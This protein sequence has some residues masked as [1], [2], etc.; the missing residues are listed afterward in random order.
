M[1]TTPADT[2]VN[3]PVAVPMVAMDVTPHIHVPPDVASLRVIVAPTHTD[4]GPDIAAGE[5][6]TVT[7]LVALHPPAVYE[8]VTTPAETP[9]TTPVVAPTVATDVLLLLHEPPD[10]ASVS[11]IVEPVHTELLPDIAAADVVTVTV[12]YAAQA[13]L[14]TR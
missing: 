9:V 5:V 4:D 2:P 6:F 12:L 11:V 10:V 7:V 8:M 1:F 3:T 14:P 13:V